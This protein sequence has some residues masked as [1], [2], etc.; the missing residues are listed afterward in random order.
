M[1]N[2][3]TQCCKIQNREYKERASSDA[4]NYGSDVGKKKTKAI[5]DGK[6]MAF[7]GKDFK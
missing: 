2:G 3:V 4:M 5:T 1:Q 7:Y 6:G